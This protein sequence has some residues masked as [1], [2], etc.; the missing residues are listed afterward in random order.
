[1]KKQEPRVK[2]VLRAPTLKLQRKRKRN[3][4]GNQEL[5]ISIS[6]SKLLDNSSHSN[7]SSHFSH[8]PQK[9]INCIFLISFAVAFNGK[10]FFIYFCDKL[11]ELCL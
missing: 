2:L 9:D 3:E 1:M 7:Y 5:F 11:G 4:G 10:G 6:I 8:F